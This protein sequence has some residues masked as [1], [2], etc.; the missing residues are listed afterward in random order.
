MSENLKMQK[1]RGFDVPVANDWAF[2]IFVVLSFI[3]VSGT[4]RD[5]YA[6]LSLSEF[7]LFALFID[8]VFGIAFAFLEIWLIVLL[9]RK[10]IRKSRTR[11][12]SAE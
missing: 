4:Y 7:G 11:K 8:V 9:P 2:W 10:L 12:S 1:K 3:N 6:G 5:H